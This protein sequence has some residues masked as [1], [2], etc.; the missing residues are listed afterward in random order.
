M[1][2]TMFWLAQLWRDHVVAPHVLFI[3]EVFAAFAPN[4][5]ELPPCAG[6][7]SGQGPVGD[8]SELSRLGRLVGDPR[9]NAGGNH[10]IATMAN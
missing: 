9:K 8:Q 2:S 6:Y 3:L 4:P 10:A 1:L 7:C 5:E